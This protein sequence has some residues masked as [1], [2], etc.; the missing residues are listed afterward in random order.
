MHV[1]Y[2]GDAIHCVIRAIPCVISPFEVKKVIKPSLRLIP[3]SD[4]CDQSKVIITKDEG[5]FPLK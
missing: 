2:L 1:P 4:I 3:F 5:D